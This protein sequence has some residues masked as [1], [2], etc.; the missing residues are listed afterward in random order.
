M[1][2]EGVVYLGVYLG[3]KF[4]FCLYFKAIALLSNKTMT[5]CFDCFLSILF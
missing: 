4:N 3:G 1:V 5:I 2:K